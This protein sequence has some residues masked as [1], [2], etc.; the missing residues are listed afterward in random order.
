MDERFPWGAIMRFGLHDLRLAPRDFWAMTLPE[1]R[2]AIGPPPAE[3]T[4]REAL[5]ELM[6]RFPDDRA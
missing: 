4:P 6:R 2:A 3:P 5:L 1:L